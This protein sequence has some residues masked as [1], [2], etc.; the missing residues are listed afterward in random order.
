MNVSDAVNSVEA[1]I[2]ETEPLAK[3]IYLEPAS[4]IDDISEGI[5]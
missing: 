4:K 3:I 5:E 1:R 2:R